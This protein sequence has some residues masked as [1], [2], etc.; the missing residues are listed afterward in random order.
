M[1]I[2][3]ILFCLFIKCSIEPRIAKLETCLQQANISYA[4]QQSP[5]WSNLTAPY[6]LRLPYAPALVVLPT[7]DQQ[8]GQSISCSA[9]ESFKV[10]PKGGGHSHASFS[11]GGQDGIVVVSMENFNEI[12]VDQSKLLCLED[13]K[14]GF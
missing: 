14:I 2:P 5:A 3:K 4:T 8:V 13:S 12:E 11:L 6:N 1:F 10:Q 9:K 7:T